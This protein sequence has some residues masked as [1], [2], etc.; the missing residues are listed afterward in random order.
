MAAHYHLMEAREIHINQR[1]YFVDGAFHVSEPKTPTSKRTIMFQAE[2]HDI[3]RAQRKRTLEEELT[4]NRC[5]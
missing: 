4:N 1:I 3:L 2:I 5:G